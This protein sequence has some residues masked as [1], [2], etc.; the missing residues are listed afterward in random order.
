MRFF[1][2]LFAT[3]LAVV[4]L[5]MLMV[6]AQT[7]NITPGENLVVEGIPEIPASLA[8]TI[9]RYTN[10][11]AAGFASWHPTRREM[12]ISTRFADTSQVHLVKFPLGSRKQMTFFPEPVS[13]ASFQPTGGDYFVFS[14]DKGGNEFNQNYRYDLGTGEVTLLTDGKSKNSRGMWANKGDRIIYTSTRRTGK[15]N[16]FYVTNPKNPQGDRLLAQ[17]EGGGWAA[18]DWSPDDSKL[19]VQEFLSVNESYLW[20]MDTSSGEKKLI[21]P[22]GVQEKV[23]YKGGIFSRDGK[24]LYVVTDKESEFSRLTYV[25]L[26]T[27]QHTYLTSEIPWDVENL[28]LSYDGKYIAFVTNEDGA[29]V[30]HLWDTSSNKQKPLPKLPVGQILGITWHRNNQD[31]G[32]SLVSA[33]STADVYS[34]NILNNKI[35][36]WTESETGGLNTASFSDSQLVRWKSFDGKTISG[37]LYRPSAKFKGKRPVIIDIHGGP[38]AQFRP[39]FLGRYNYYL[40]ELGVAL[41]FPNVRGSTGYGKTFL[42]LDNG[43]KRENSVK[44]IGALL[45]WISTQPDLDKDRILVTGG[46]YG[47]YMSL[48]VGTKYG[49]KI[50]AS[51]DIVGISNFVT[52]LEKTES[53][54][55]DLRRVEYGDERDGKMREFL[56]KISP[57]NNAE[58]IKKPLFVVHGKN[59]P[60]V[61]LNEAEQMLAT[62]RKNN[63]PVWYLMAKDEGHGFSK[64]KNVD[65]QFYATVMFVKEYLLGIGKN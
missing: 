13:G 60:R 30:L 42:Q 33:R 52:F 50:R 28:D 48:A 18:L 34:L 45:D 46:S 53:Y 63:I 61:P 11:R 26:A 27:M 23:S 47:G 25:D 65:F 22:K 19:L 35:E 40:N 44:D 49:D 64:K 2:K 14:K 3:F 57:L 56:L 55:R 38:E 9:E 32:F 1:S 17:V 31:L 37:S 5:P 59:D 39:T 7:P 20:L 10:F 12:L 54:R 4:L 29:G 8:E 36:R 58:Q 41:L 43:Y 6:A 62:V 24:G 21:T 15:D 16:D 51:I